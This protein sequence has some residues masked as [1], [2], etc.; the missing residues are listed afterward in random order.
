M[1]RN[2]DVYNYSYYIF[3]VEF[4]FFSHQDDDGMSILHA[5]AKIGSL[6]AIQFILSLRKVSINVQV[7]PKSTKITS[8][9]KKVSSIFCIKKKKKKKKDLNCIIFS[10]WLWMFMLL[11]SILSYGNV[12][13]TEWA[14]CISLCYYNETFNT[15]DLHYFSKVPCCRWQV[16]MPTPLHPINP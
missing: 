6:E 12:K 16:A 8:S 3:V 14:C 10:E 9:W 11:P 13:P 15:S 1:R 2:L 5:A 7:S 4:F